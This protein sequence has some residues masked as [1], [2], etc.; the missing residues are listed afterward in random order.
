MNTT[1]RIKRKEQHRSAETENRTRQTSDDAMQGLAEGD[2]GDSEA[3]HTQVRILQDVLPL[4]KVEAAGKV[5]RA[6]G[7]RQLGV[8]VRVGV[9][10][11]HAA[12]VLGTSVDAQPA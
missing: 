9:E 12:V 3:R 10:W 6:V 2:C 1:V 5:G 11:G 4:V 7:G 8:A